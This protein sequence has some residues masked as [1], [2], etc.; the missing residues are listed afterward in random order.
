MNRLTLVRA[1]W[2]AALLLAPGTVLRAAPHQQI[3][4]PARTVARVL[5]ARDL[6]QAAVISRRPTRTWILAGTGVDATH[7]TTMVA[8]A[9]LKPNR[10]TLALSSAATASAFVLAGVHQAKA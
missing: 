4:H 6:A 10:R 1:A 8:L 9:L 2:G 7:A 5:G 3:D